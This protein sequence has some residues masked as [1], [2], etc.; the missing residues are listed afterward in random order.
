M[1]RL[2]RISTIMLL[3]GVSLFTGSCARNP[4]PTVTDNPNPIL[5]SLFPIN[6]PAGA[7]SFQVTVNARNAP[8]LTLIRDPNHPGRLFGG[9]INAGTTQS[10][11]GA[12]LSIDDGLS[13]TPYGLDGKTVASL[14]LT[15]DSKFIYASAYKSGIYS[16]KLP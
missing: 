3:L 14:A 8:H 1:P 11:G 7:G 5:A 15:S 12:F 9:N 4:T 6:A 2:Y 16:M 10:S 13:F